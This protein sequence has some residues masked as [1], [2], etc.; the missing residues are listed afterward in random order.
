M[1]DVRALFE[2]AYAN[3]GPPW[4]IG[5]PQPVVV[6]LERAG[7]I[8][9][10]V[11]DPGCGTGEHTIHLA[12]KGY[13]VLGI[14]FSARAIELAEQNAR[15]RGAQADFRVAD[16]FQLSGERFD[17]VIDSA[18][19][20]VFE[21]PD[22]RRYVQHLAELCNPGAVVHVLAL[23]DTEPQLGPR[24]TS[25][26]IR[27]AFAEGWE[28]AYVRSSSYR[29]IARGESAVAFGV[30]SGSVVAASAWLAKAVRR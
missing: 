29:A 8:S 13:S 16:V 24:V 1:E 23:A 17:T 20:H 30:T 10:A 19:F 21:P 5:E 9:G 7:E 22:R 12:T 3:G 25:T 14:D 18:L 6:E 27:E 2:S 4:V 15:R 26:A 28:L 11:L